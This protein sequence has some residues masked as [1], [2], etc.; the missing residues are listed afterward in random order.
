MVVVA[1]SGLE[2]YS[3]LKTT[4]SAVKGLPS[5]KF[6]FFLSFQVTARPSFATPPFSR[7]GIWAARIGTR[8]PFASQ[9]ASGS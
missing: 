4:S 7:E 9:A 2:A 5:W 3:T 8:L 1:V 6:T